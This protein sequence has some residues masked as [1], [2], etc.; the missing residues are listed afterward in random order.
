M[1]K[2]DKSIWVKYLF[3]YLIL[4]NKPLSCKLLVVAFQVGNCPCWPREREKN[5]F[6]YTTCFKFITVLRGSCVNCSNDCFQGAYKTANGTE[7]WCVCFFC[8]CCRGKLWVTHHR[9]SQQ[10][11]LEELKLAFGDSL[12]NVQSLQDCYSHQMDSIQTLGSTNTHINH[13]KPVQTHRLTLGH[14]SQTHTEKNK[15][16]TRLRKRELLYPSKKLVLD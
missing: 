14:K 13:N 9:I 12:A 2:N 1:W 4:I 11:S 15:Q 10:E 8:C 6:L 5:L 16:I 7:A 3:Q